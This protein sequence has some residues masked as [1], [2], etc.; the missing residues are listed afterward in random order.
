MAA[1]SVFGQVLKRLGAPG[2]ELLTG[3]GSK[4][5]NGNVATNNEETT[6]VHDRKIDGY[7]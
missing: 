7:W 6:M 2:V 4:C 3:C 1:Q 5:G